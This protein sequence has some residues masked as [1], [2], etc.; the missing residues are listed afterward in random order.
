[1]PL[2]RRSPG[3]PRLAPPA[4]VSLPLTARSLPRRDDHRRYPTISKSIASIYNCSDQIEGTYYVLADLTEVCYEGL[5]IVFMF[6]AFIGAL[7]YTLGIPIV[8]AVVTA[9]RSPFY[10]DA[11]RRVS[12]R[13]CARRKPAEYATSKVRSRYAFLFNGTFAR[14]TNRVLGVP[15]HARADGR[16]QWSSRTI[17]TPS[18]RLPHARSVLRMCRLLHG[19]L[20]HRRL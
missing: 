6:I 20:R 2:R 16:S 11:N 9:F 7:V 17:L 13:R 19:P 4:H 15:R 14:A 3:P 18:P 8:M 1:M 12:L 10:C 5:H